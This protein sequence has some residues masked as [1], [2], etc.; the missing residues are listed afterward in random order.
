MKFLLKVVG[1]LI[2][3]LLVLFLGAYLRYNEPLPKGTSGPDADRLGRK[4]MT[5]VGSEQL[6]STAILVWTFAGSHRYVWDRKRNLV[7]VAWGDT[8]VLLNLDTWEKG[9]AY[10]DGKEVSDPGELD[11]KRGK[12]WE[13]FVNDSFWFIAP[14]KAF[15]AGV[16]RSLVKQEDGTEALLV[17]YTSGGVT[18]GDSYLWLLDGNGLPYAFKLWVSIIPIGGIKATWSGWKTLKSGLKVAT[19][20]E[21]GPVPLSISDTQTATSF[22]ELGRSGDP[23]AAVL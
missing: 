21:L 4:M 3:V 7:E 15:D 13:L 1:G 16:K 11:N 17:T 18:P 5:A 23:F 20:H 6:D 9:R 14:T 19:V 12:A 8:Q 2:A 22:Q 10:E